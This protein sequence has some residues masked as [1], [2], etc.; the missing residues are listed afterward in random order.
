MNSLVSLSTVAHVWLTFPNTSSLNLRSSIIAKDRSVILSITKKNYIQIS[1]HQFIHI[2]PPILLPSSLIHSDY[3][4]YYKNYLYTLF[5]YPGR[6]LFLRHLQ[7]LDMS[8]PAS[9][10][11]SFSPVAHLSSL[12][13]QP[14]CDSH[15]MSLVCSL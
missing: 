4:L 1:I 6:L 3:F 2:W 11:L 13:L 14:S 12:S 15:Q 5:S 8:C 7:W 9:L 10:T